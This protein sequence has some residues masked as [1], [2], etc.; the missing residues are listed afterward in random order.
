MDAIYWMQSYGNRD[1]LLASVSDDATKQFLDLNYGPWDRLDNNAPFVP[2]IGARPP[3]AN[4][5]PH[6]ITKAQFDSAVAKGP[7]A[8]ADSLKSLYTLVRRGPDSTLV[9]VPYK[10]AYKAQNEIAAAKLREAAKLAE[11]LQWVD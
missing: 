8:H 3:G 4:L 2:S 7:A 5:Y 10:V 9:A 6:D 11:E 1:S